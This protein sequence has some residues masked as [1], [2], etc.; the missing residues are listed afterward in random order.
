MHELRVV[1]AP[2]ALR[3][4][5]LATT[6]GESGTETI[7]KAHLLAEPSHPRAMQWL[8]E[9]IALWQ[10]QRVR[11]ALVADGTHRSCGSSLYGDWFSDFGGAL[12]TL[13]VVDPRERRA[14]RDR[15]DAMGSFAD[16]RQ[17]VLFRRR[18]GR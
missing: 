12:Y 9:A 6:H 15:I 18:E 8:L 5:V 10:G 7:L 3:T 11:A 4:R 2:N 13:D 14:H 16:L 17:L 1:L